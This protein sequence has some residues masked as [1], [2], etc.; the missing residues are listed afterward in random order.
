MR[1]SDFDF[2]QIILFVTQHTGIIPRVSHRDGI[3]LYVE[4]RLDAIEMSVTDYMRL[5]END[6]DEL[7]FLVNESTVNE[8]YFFREEKQFALLKDKIFP[9][10]TA[11][12]GSQQFKIWCAASSS[13]EEVYSLLLLARACHLSPVITASDIDT[14]MLTLCSQ[15]EYRERSKRSTDGTMFHYLLEPYTE[16]NGGVYFSEELKKSINT[17]QI[18]LAALQNLPI[19]ALPQMQNLIFVR[20][21]FIYFSMELRAAILKVLV[22]KCLAPNGY[23]FVSMNEI[24]SIDASI[25]PN[26]LEKCSD[27]SVFYFRKK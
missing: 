11:R 22:E 13:G 3:R 2:E 17:R 1:I 26:G 19:G 10:W 16:C 14:Y 24:A 23:L 5:I 6:T 25:I 21:V 7:A 8:T 9:E 27:G 20:N 12:N 4:K 18:N 15:G